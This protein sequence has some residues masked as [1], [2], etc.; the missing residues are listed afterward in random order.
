MRN[1][2][3][4]HRFGQAPPLRRGALLETSAVLAA[5]WLAI[6]SPLPRALAADQPAAGS[7]T[8]A[9]K[10]I[11]PVQNK[12]QVYPTPD[13]TGE[14]LSR[15]TLT[16][17]WGGTRQEWANKGITLDA[18][19]TQVGMGVVS[20]GRD[21]GWEY[22]GR[23]EID[24]N[25]DTAKLGLWPGGLFSVIAE[26]HFGRSIFPH[27]GALLPADL[28][29]AIPEV[30]DSFVI[31]QLMY[32]QFLSEKLGIFVG[33]MTTITPNSGDMNEFA[34]GKGDHQFLNTAFCADPVILLTAP[35]STFGAGV[36]VLPTKD[37]VITA[38][39]LDP[40]GRAD[41]AQLDHLFS[42]G[43]TINVEGRYTTRFFDMTGHQLLG[44][45]YSTSS[46]TDLDQRV[47]NLI[48]PGLPTE[49]ADSAW[50][51]YYNFDQYFYQPDPKVN[52]GIGLFTR[53]GVSDGQ[54]NPIHWFASG[55]I[56]GKGMIS[57]RPNDAFGIGYY[58]TWIA[59]TQITSR[60]GFADAQGV[61]AFYDIALT[62][63]LHLT[64]DVQWIQPS[65]E[66]VDDSWIVGFRL[67]MAF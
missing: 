32:T 8:D 12:N 11:A 7:A 53:A 58:Y 23:G 50:S 39:A 18:Y 27:T 55:G 13:Y 64:P 14:F 3:R 45:T 5:A 57:G 26:G 65:Q 46:Y 21:S 22:L 47:A 51:V 36:I 60:L 63:W 62:P 66:R 37:L 19:L 67:Y 38:A 41:S 33:K 9:T 15:S 35:Y 30:D 54:A 28:N 6:A 40:H 52:K 48:L 31:P 25:L 42:D 61:E 17:D 49:K 10:T 59:D 34:H 43:V 4:I 44:G 29:E 16:G 1:R 56:G 20:G 2:F 24:L